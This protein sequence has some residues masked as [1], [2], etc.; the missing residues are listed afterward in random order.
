VWL[1]EIRYQLGLR[2]ARRRNER[3]NEIATYMNG[4]QQVLFQ[5]GETAW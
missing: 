4:R 5:E 2:R 1:D 3:Q